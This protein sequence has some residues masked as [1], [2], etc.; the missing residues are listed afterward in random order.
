MSLTMLDELDAMGAAIR[1]AERTPK[2]RRTT[3][4]R[5][6]ISYWSQLEQRFKTRWTTCVFR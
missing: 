1:E 6:Q 4:S 2:R 5:V 3:A